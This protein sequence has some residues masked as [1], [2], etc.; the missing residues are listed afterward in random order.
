MGRRADGFQNELVALGD[1]VARRRNALGL[2]QPQLAASAGLSL[3]GL[4]RIE[5]ARAAPSI[6]SLF[7]IAGALGC[8]VPDLFQKPHRSSRAQRVATILEGQPDDVIEATMV[9]ARA[10]VKLQSR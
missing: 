4:L 1:E 7:Q 6:V 10:I 5:K 8:A 9:C 3:D 2:T